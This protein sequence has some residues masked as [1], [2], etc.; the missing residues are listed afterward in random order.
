M[1]SSAPEMDLRA[2][3]RRKRQGFGIILGSLALT[4]IVLLA[5]LRALPPAL[6]L[7]LGMAFPLAGLEVGYGRAYGAPGRRTA[8][9]VAVVVLLA[10]AYA[11]A[12]VHFGWRPAL[13]GQR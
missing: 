7:W 4:P 2:V 12:H 5:A 9:G 6:G 11:W 3:D 8:V 10:G 13:R 1:E